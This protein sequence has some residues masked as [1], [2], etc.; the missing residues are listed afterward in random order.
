V[1]VRIEELADGTMHTAEIIEKPAA[2][3]TVV[4]MD[5]VVA[6]VVVGDEEYVAVVLQRRTRLVDVAANIGLFRMLLVRP[7]VVA[8]AVVVDGTR[9]TGFV[10]RDRLIEGLVVGAGLRTGESAGLSDP[11]LYGDPVPVCGAVRIRCRTCG[12]IGAYDFYLPGELVQC[13]GTPGHQL[14]VEL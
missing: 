12:V 4:L 7:P 3:P 9:V 11:L 13:T 14:D 6:K 10:P 2:E 8:G 5:G 1:R